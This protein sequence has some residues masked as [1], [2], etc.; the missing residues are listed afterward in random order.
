MQRSFKRNYQ[1]T[2]EFSRVEYRKKTDE[3]K[4]RKFYV[5][6]TLMST[7][8]AFYEIRKSSF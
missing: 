5:V 6:M 3:N 4:S 2:C 7:G 1:H 8:F